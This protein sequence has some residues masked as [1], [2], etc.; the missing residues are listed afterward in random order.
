[1][2]LIYAGGPHRP[3]YTIDDL[4][5][6][7][8]VIDTSDHPVGWLSDGALFLEYW[9]VSGRYYMTWPNGAPSTNNDWTTYLDSLFAPRGPMTRLDSAA[10][11]VG[12]AVGTPGKRVGVAIMVPYPDPR[13][14]TLRFGEHLFRTTSETDRVAV[15]V[16]Y[17]REASRRFATLKR[18]HETLKAFYWM[19]EVIHDADSS[20]VRQVSVEVH[21]QGFRFI[22]IPAYRAAGWD[23]WRSL[24][25]DQAWLQPNYFFHPEVPAVRLDSALTLARGAGMGIE[26]EFDRRMFDTWQFADRL[27]PYLAL[28]ES[29]ADMRGQPIA[30]YDGGGALFRLARSK[31][32][33]QRALYQRLVAALR[34]ADQP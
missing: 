31:D 11:L 5:H 17:V 25:F 13:A 8:A 12:T 22:W 18:A 33:W 23:K 2:I 29:A 1:M 6:L 15:A 3:A 32:S 4:A 16:A 28:L 30:I 10:A 24:G 21:K 14:D 19:N 26:L 7:L 34:V 9:T 20:L 27:E